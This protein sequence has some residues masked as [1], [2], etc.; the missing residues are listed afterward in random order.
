MSRAQKTTKKKMKKA[1]KSEEGKEDEAEEDS[2]KK[3]CHAGVQQISISAQSRKNW[4]REGELGKL[5][6]ILQS[7]Q[8]SSWP[9]ARAALKCAARS[10]QRIFAK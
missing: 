7:Q 6:R 5:K 4:K 3:L 9:V 10:A 1:A 2:E 8:A